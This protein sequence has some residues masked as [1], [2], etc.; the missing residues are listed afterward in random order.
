MIFRV[1]GPDKE[2]KMRTEYVSCIP[3]E[4]LDSM[5]QA[6]YT[7]EIDGKK[8]S[9]AAV[10]KLRET[11]ASPSEQVAQPVEGK[12]VIHCITTDEYFAK[13]SIAA[14]Y[15]GIDPAAVSDSIKTGKVRS[16]YQFE[17]CNLPEGKELK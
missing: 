5:Q 12:L 11:P 8:A 15:L 7:F 3:F 2:A 16:G 14:K 6:G 13:Q 4:H 17:K 10:L 1:I 9:K